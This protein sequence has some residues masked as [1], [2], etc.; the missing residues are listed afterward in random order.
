MLFSRV[1]KPTSAWEPESGL[2]GLRKFKNG[3]GLKGLG[4]G[5]ADG[6]EYDYF[7]V[8]ATLNELLYCFYSNFGSVF[9][10]AKPQTW[11]LPDGSWRCMFICQPPPIRATV[12][13]P[14]PHEGAIEHPN[15]CSKAT[16]VVIPKAKGLIVGDIAACNTDRTCPHGGDGRSIIYIANRY[17]LPE[18]EELETMDF[19]PWDVIQGF[20]P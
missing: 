9:K 4:I 15:G 7:G 11:D 8:S 12:G 20:T 18:A 19:I 10:P 5:T 1:A 14:C 2:H 17:F 3:Y 16:R 13:Y 6:L